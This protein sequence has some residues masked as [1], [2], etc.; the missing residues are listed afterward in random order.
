MMPS[1]S[2]IECEE[3]AIPLQS[4]V[5]TVVKSGDHGDPVGVLS[6]LN[7]KRYEA[8]QS[9]KEIKAYLLRH[10]KSDSTKASLESVS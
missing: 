2:V 6:V 7:T 5:G 3:W 4:T 10:C 9:L 8:L 1:I